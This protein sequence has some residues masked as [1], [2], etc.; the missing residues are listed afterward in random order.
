MDSTRLPKGHLELIKSLESSYLKHDDPILQSGFGGGPLRWKTER[1]PILEA[2]ESDGDIMDVGC[3]NGYLLECLLEWGM[4]RGLSLTPH[5]LDISS[6]LI[7][8]AKRRLP[9]FTANFHV[10]NGWEWSPV[11]SYRYVYSVYDCVPESYL[12]EYV[13]RLL[14]RVVEPGGRLILGAYGSRSEG[15]LPF[16]IVESLKSLGYHVAGS[17]GGGEPTTALFGWVDRPSSIS[18]EI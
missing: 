10:G 8:V 6:R 9:Q 14:H 2:M 5:G 4:E 7:E 16:D 3:A 1:S 13:R 17:A 18:G 12:P 15:R 11:Q